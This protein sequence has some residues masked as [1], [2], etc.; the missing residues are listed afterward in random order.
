MNPYKLEEK[1]I[2][3]E[4]RKTVIEKEKFISKIKSGFGDEIKKNAGVINVKKVSRFK[5]I[6]NR[7]MN[8]F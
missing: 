7:I 6:L 1:G 3:Y 4:K 2:E 8:T 5:R